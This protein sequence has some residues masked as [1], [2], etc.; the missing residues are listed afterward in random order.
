VPFKL[1]RYRTGDAALDQELAGIIERTGAD[2]DLDLLFE[3]LVSGVGLATDDTDRLDLK[4]SS[5]ALK[6]MRAAFKMFAPYRDVP[7]V[8]MF[9]SAR[10]LP[11][12]PVYRQA[13]DIAAAIAAH[14][15]MVVT[16]AG[17]G[18]MQAGMEGAGRK[19]SVGVS[20]RLPFETNA[21]PTIA[22]DEKLV[23]MKYFFTRK[24]MLVKESS[25]FVALPGGVGTLDEVLELLTLQQTGKAEPAPLVL[26]DTPGDT[27]WEEW[28]AYVRTSLLP[29]GVISPE[30][31]SLYEV[32]NDPAEAVGHLLGFYRNYHSIRWVG[33]RLVIRL[34]AKP[35]KDEV[36]D[37]NER[38]GDLCVTGTIEARGPLSVEKGEGDHIDLPRLTMIYDPFK[39]AMLHTL[40]HAVNA[41]PS[42]PPAPA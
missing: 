3:I 20:I 19:M 28:D 6:E 10:T 2:D 39:P 38:F 7:K 15:W 42:A 14:G 1:P 21:N 40:I 13:H 4:I 5:A 31:L 30:D 35:T 23:S 36:T 12:A 32:A 17:P 41:L 37:L 9:G 27:F 8:T 33:S 26:L 34:K 16:G 29:R 22:G 18:I 11:D 25:G 24:L